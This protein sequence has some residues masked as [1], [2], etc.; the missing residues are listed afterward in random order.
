MRQL[1]RPNSSPALLPHPYQVGGSL[2][3]AATTYIARQA[4]Q[5]LFEALITGEFCFVLNAHQTGKSSLRWRAMEQLQKRNVACVGIDLTLL[6]TRQL[7]AEQWYGAIAA[8]LVKGFCLPISIS[9]WWRTHQHLS[10]VSRLTS[11]IDSVLLVHIQQPIVIFLDEIES[12]LGL[13]FPADDLFAAISNYYQHRLL[14]PAYRRLNFVLMGTASPHA[15]FSDHLELMTTGKAVPLP[16]FTS[17]QAKR[18]ADSLRGW[19]QNPEAVIQRI[20]YWTNGQPFLTQKLCRLVVEAVQQQ[21][22]VKFSASDRWIDD[23]VHRRI[24]DNWEPQDTPEHLR[25]IR[26]RL[27]YTPKFSSDLLALYRCILLADKLSQRP[28]REDGSALQEALLL[29]GLV[30][31]QKGALRVH[32]KIYRE[33]FNLD[34]CNSQ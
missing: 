23:L 5:Q 10:P 9:Q 34:W 28:V 31:E 15:L 27:L 16:S 32:N 7:T 8:E 3:S 4:D 2:K 11:L 25:T 29:T 30:S 19:C 33:V 24:I 17:L 12:I 6:G 1:A 22:S 13:D 18:L 21:A 26:D 20:I 14:F